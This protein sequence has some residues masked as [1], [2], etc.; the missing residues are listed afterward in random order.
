MRIREPYRKRLFYYAKNHPAQHWPPHRANPADHRHQKDRDA[1][2]KSENVSGI[3]ERV[4]A[5]IKP[6]GHAGKSGGNCVDPEL[7]K[8][9]IHAQIGSGLLVLLDGAKRQAKFT[10]HYQ[11]RDGDRQGS[12]DDG[13]VIVL[14]LVEWRML[15]DAISAGAASDI[16]I[17]HDH[18]R[19]F[20]D[21]DGG[22]SEIWPGQPE[23]WQSHQ[24]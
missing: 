5:R 18:T 11:C 2:G 16:K 17:V 14:K 13:R 9:R 8:I 22:D 7:G 21:S 3:N 4:I 23:G 24:E 20:T 10:V 19:S 6:A 1:G 12:D 15:H